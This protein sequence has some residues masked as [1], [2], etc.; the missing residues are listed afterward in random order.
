MDVPYKQAQA[1]SQKTTWGMSMAFGEGALW[2]ML[3]KS[4]GERMS[5]KGVMPCRLKISVAAEPFVPME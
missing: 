4:C 3:A 5:R 2:G 1:M